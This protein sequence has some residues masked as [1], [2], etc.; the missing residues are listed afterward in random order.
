MFERFEKNEGYMTSPIMTSKLLWRHRNLPIVDVEQPVEGQVEAEGD[1]D[2]G[3]VAR[4]DGL[5]ERGEN[6]DHVRD[7]EDLVILWVNFSI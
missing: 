2:G 7:V 5:V 3:G 6:G 4:R 1:V